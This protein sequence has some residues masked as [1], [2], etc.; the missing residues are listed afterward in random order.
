MGSLQTAYQ[1]VTVWHHYTS[2]IK[3]KRTGNI[4]YSASGLLRR[5]RKRQSLF[6]TCGKGRGEDEYVSELINKIKQHQCICLPH[7]LSRVRYTVYS[8]IYFVTGL[9]CQC[10]SKGITALCT[11]NRMKQINSVRKMGSY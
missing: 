9:L 10:C 2:Q 3:N 5:I 6:I 11:E 1:P 8:L 7:A 4:L